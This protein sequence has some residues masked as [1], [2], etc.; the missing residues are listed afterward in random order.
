LSIIFSTANHLTSILKIVPSCPSLRVIVCF[1][2]LPEAE[3]KVL[4]DWA[5]HVGVELLDFD[6]LE[7]WGA[8]DGIRTDPGPVKGIHGE[9]ELDQYRVASISYT[10]GTTGKPSPA[11]WA[12]S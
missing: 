1:D 10:S 9:P 12:K 4:R 7:K 6:D 5:H 2:P 11:M 3:G 8:E